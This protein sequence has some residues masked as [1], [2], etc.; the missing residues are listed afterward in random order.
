[1][2]VTIHYRFIRQEMP[3]ELLKKAEIIAKELNFKILKR[4]WNKLILHPSE[5]CE[6]IELHWHKY[7]TIKKREGWDYEKETLKDKEIDDDYWVVSGFTK[8]QYAGYSTHMKVAEFL[9][10]IA[11]YCTETEVYDEAHYY[12]SQDIEKLKENLDSSS[13]MIANIAGLLK[14]TFGKENVVTGDEL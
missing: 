2:G 8:T 10:F 13:K 7:K 11:R 4:S 12:E 1:M 5:D 14:E 6:T 3:E 9:R